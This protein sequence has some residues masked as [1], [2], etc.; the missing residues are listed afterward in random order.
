M[1]YTI[2]ETARKLNISRQTIY[3]KLT[4][5][6]ETIQP[7]INK[8][9]NITYLNEH[10]INIIKADISGNVNDCFEKNYKWQL[11]NLKELN[12]IL[13]ENLEYL[14]EEL[15]RKNAIIEKLLLIMKVESIDGKTY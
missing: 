14:K 2:T 8:K 7:F 12:K 4:A 3:N 15:N 5:L 1:E 9:G 10:A 6:N 13:S 11:N